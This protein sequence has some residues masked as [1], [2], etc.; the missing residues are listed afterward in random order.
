[1]EE[2]LTNPDITQTDKKEYIQP[3][4]GI[5]PITSTGIA[6]FHN[7]NID[8]LICR[9]NGTTYKLFEE[10]PSISIKTDDNEH[11]I[12]IAGKYANGLVEALNKKIL[13]SVILCSP[14]YEQLNDM[15]AEI[16]EL[17]LELKKNELL[18]GYERLSLFYFPTFILLSNGIMYDEA[19]Y[20]LQK[21][22]EGLDL[23]EKIINNICG[24]IIRGS[25][26][27]EAYREGNTYIPFNNEVLKIAVPRYD[28]FIQV[29]ELLNSKNFK[30]SI[31]KNPHKVEF[32]KAII[33]I[34][35]STA[36]MIFC[37]DRNDFRLKKISVQE[38]LEPTG[39]AKRELINHFQLAIFEIGQH[40]GA[41]SKAENFDTTWQP[42]KEQILKSDSHKTCNSIYC[43]SQMIKTNNF[44]GKLPS[45]E[46]SLIHPLK[47]Y[48]KHYGLHEHVI[49]FEKLEETI[50]NTLEFAQKNSDKIIF[51]F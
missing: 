42:R 29:V 6:L 15:I 23:Q 3:T 35:T 44:P 26:L 20:N 30:F 12:E 38:A 45:L 40:A 34:A 32:E 36:A 24:K 49:L 22:L 33:N 14:S 46:Y 4:T 27:K 47:G 11:K 31:Q 5:Y 25:I 13:P 7:Y 16:T 41:F 2:K 8:L 18:K 17:A 39:K 50:L 48:A 43:L 19:I 51:T 21:S 9:K 28:L 37:L 1:M 10:S